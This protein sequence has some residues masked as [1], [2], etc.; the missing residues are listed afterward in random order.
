MKFI[1][2]PQDYLKHLEVQ[3][4]MNNGVKVLES[5]EAQNNIKQLNQKLHE[6]EKC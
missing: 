5:E 1:P 2:T 6:S 4:W 3:P